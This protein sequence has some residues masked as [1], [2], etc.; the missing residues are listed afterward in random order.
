MP[1]KALPPPRF[2]G[3]NII[4]EGDDVDFEKGVCECQHDVIGRILMQKGDHHYK[5]LELFDKLVLLW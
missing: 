1:I 3:G 2:E 4:I 5:T